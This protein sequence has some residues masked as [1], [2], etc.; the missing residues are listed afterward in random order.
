MRRFK[1]DVKTAAGRTAVIT[2]PD[3]N[4]MANVLRMKAGDSVVLFDGTGQEYTAR[5]EKI[6]RGKVRLSFEESRPSRAESPAR[7]TVAQGFL[8]DRKM[9]MLIRQLTELG[10]SRWIPFLADRSVARP[11]VERLKKRMDRWRKIADEA[12]KQCR[13]ARSPRMETA[14]DFKAM[15]KMADAS[16]LKLIFWEEETAAFAGDGRA[17]AE[18]DQQEL[19]LVIGPEGGFTADEINLARQ[20][21]FQPLSLGPRILRAETAAVAAAALVQYRFGD[22]GLGRRGDQG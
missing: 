14:A 16:A 17:A 3:A 11:N 10:I 20:A 12:L 7:I 6:T 21:G 4:H 19:F 8:K 5:I 15:L 13:R 9:D 22:L 2:G 1:I 18:T